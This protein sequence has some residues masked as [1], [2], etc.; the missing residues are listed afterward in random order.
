MKLTPIENRSNSNKKSSSAK[1]SNP[2]KAEAMPLSRTFEVKVRHDGAIN[3][4]KKGNAMLGIRKGSTVTVTVTEGKA[5]IEPKGY[6]CSVCGMPSN[7]ALD[8]SGI[9]CDCNKLVVDAIQKG[10]AKSVAEAIAY[11]QDMR[12]ATIKRK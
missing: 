2:T 8:V 10:K 1:K 11:A 12:A 7:S 9:C 6:V 5:T 4:R 3:L